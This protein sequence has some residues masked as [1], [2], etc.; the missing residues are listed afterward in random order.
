[1]LA[2]E[3]TL[4]YVR[5]AYENQPRLWSL[6]SN[7]CLYHKAAE[8]VHVCHHDHSF[9][10]QSHRIRQLY[11]ARQE[12]PVLHLPVASF[13]VPGT[14]PGKTCRRLLGLIRQLNSWPG[15]AR[16]VI[17]IC[18]QAKQAVSLHLN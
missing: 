4:P 17:G 9:D 15:Y 2:H 16:V 12:E 7:T 11:T 5:D 14:A 8:T 10:Q 1:M 13:Q 3:R 18:Q 6:L